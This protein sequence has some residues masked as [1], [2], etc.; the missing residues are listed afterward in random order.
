MD[1]KRWLGVMELEDKSLYG[2]FIYLMAFFPEFRN[3]FYYRIGSLKHFISFL[4][5]GMS[6]LFITCPEIGAGLFLQ[7]GFST[8]I[9][10]N[11][12][13]TNCWINQQVT[14]GFS[15]KTDRPTLKNNVTV[16]AGAKIIGNVVI[17]N[18]VIVGAN[19]VVVKDVPDN[20]TVVGVPARILKV[21]DL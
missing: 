4:C 17:G 20:C 1:T 5:R 18:N 12:I 10:A 11:S 21:R 7:H 19:A 15:N 6:T 16:Y 9:N 13:G 2:G 14:I 3:L 8:I